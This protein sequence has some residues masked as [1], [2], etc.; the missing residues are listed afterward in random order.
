MPSLAGT[1]ISI[2]SAKNPR[3][4]ISVSGNGP[5]A[6]KF[7]S[8]RYVNSPW[9]EKPL[10]FAPA[11]NDRFWYVSLLTV[12]P[13]AS[14]SASNG[15]VPS[16][17]LIWVALDVAVPIGVYRPSREVQPDRPNCV[18]TA[19]CSSRSPNPPRGPNSPVVGWIHM[20]ALYDMSRLS[21]ATV[22]PSWLMLRSTATV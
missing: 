2:A 9:N 19:L 17:S 22:F 16:E 3:S 5:V 7:D 21:S 10:Y 18:A 15:L 8:L 20:L 1:T 11:S 6:S 4:L 13:F 14:A 12:T